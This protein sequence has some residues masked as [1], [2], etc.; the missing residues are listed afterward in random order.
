MPT[1]V[2]G[3][4]ERV[5]FENEETGLRVI[6]VGHVAGR[7]TIA[8]VGNFAAVGPGTKVR[9]TGDFVNDPR[10]G[11]QFRVE[12]LVPVAPDTRTFT[13]APP[14]AEAWHRSKSVSIF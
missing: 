8:V 14:A 13:L 6:K 12:T 7:G 3:E 11:E 2:T 10:H 9:L 4:V 5:T 1:T